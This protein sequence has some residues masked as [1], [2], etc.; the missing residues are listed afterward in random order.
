MAYLLFKCWHERLFHLNRDEMHPCHTEAKVEFVPIDEQNAGL[1]ANLRGDT[2]VEQFKNQLRMG[3]FGY[4][5]F[6]DGKPVAYGFV[7]HQGSGDYFYRIGDGCLYLCRFFTHEGARGKGIYP[8]L[9]TALIE[10]EADCRSFYICTERGNVASE[11]GLLKVGFQFIG[12][13]GFIRGF[14]HTFNKKKL[15]K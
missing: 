12:E 3:D 8:A 2:Y 15:K 14:K 13:Y 6:L 5:A 4:Y 1:V 9:I 10:R 11:R 7:K